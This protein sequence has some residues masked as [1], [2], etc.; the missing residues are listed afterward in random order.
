MFASP[1]MPAD[2]SHIGTTLLKSID[3]R[4]QIADNRRELQADLYRE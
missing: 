3:E 2:E 4:R 1:L